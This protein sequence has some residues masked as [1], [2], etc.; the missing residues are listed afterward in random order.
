VHE[1]VYIYNPAST[2]RKLL[3]TVSLVARGGA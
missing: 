1:L 3:D 2:P